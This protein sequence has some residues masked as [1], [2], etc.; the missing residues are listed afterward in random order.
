VKRDKSC[1]G[2]QWGEKESFCTAAP[3]PYLCS[4]RERLVKKKSQQRPVAADVKT[5]FLLTRNDSVFA[6]V[7][8][9]TVQQ[10]CLEV[11]AGYVA[12]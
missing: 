2:S 4:S 9:S 5:P 3:Q 7:I 12:K 8:T 10:F 11:M 1:C 6:K